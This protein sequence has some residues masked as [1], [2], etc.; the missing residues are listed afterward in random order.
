MELIDKV[1]KKEIRS[2]ERIKDTF[3][4][5]FDYLRMDKNERIIPFKKDQL[6]G[7]KSTIK[8]EDISGYTELGFSYRK[9][10]SYLEVDPSQI[11]LANGSDLAIKSVY[12][13]CVERANNVVLHMPSF[14]MYRVY[15]WMFG[16][17]VKSVP[18]KEDW[19]VDFDKMLGAVDD[20]TKMMVLEDPNGFI[21]TRPDFSQIE[22]CAK[23]L[24][25]RNTLLLIDEAYYFIED[26]RCKSLSL[27]SK[28]PNL[29][30]SQTFS[31]C[32]GLAGTRFGYLVGHPDLMQ[33]ISRVKPMHEIT[34]LT[35]RAAEWILDHPEILDDYR[36][37]VKES[38]SF[39]IKELERLNFKC[40]DTHANFILVYFPK[41]G[42]T[43]AMT[44]KLKER[45][46]LIR[47]PFEEPYL[48][49]W[50]RIT[51]GS[52]QDA[53]TFIKTVREILKQ[54]DYEVR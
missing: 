20:D 43:K 9:L 13:A 27:I 44:Q 54:V 1:V 39:L 5:R 22:Y 16:A 42:I 18:V 2:L 48:K 8:S 34:G 24:K 6:E 3:D 36:K 26:S 11:L 17:E 12:E 32:H 21:G 10:A 50:C 33:Y 35:A 38:K 7:F 19:S 30:I 47:R 41:E 31:K 45:R 15:A 29:I 4:D 49:G 52:L 14:A 23:E 28:Y 37:S 46:I 40:R 51:V 25:N 53:H